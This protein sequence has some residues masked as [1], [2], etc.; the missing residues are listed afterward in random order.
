MV[1]NAQRYLVDLNCI[2]L[3]VHVD[4]W[5]DMHPK[6]GEDI[7]AFARRCLMGFYREQDGCLESIVAPS[8]MCRIP[9]EVIVRTVGGRV[10]YRSTL[11]R[12]AD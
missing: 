9:D 10:V 6:K 8:E 4:T 3:N 2:A 11:A 12:R 5:D 1:H 7:S